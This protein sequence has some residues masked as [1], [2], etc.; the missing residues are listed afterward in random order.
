MKRCQC[1]RCNC[2][3]KIKEFGHRFEEENAIAEAQYQKDS[4]KVESII[5]EICESCEKGQHQGN[6]KS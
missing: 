3:N 5:K 2:P 4:D 1:E 6:P